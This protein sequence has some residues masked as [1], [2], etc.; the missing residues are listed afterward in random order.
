M[1]V[2]PEY[3]K[4]VRYDASKLIAL[5]GP[6][7]MTP[8]EHGIDATLDWLTRRDARLRPASGP[9]QPSPALTRSFPACIPAAP[10]RLMPPATG[11]SISTWTTSTRWRWYSRHSPNSSA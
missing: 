1:Q 10:P 9:R 4:P 5:L 11:R 3:M 6:Q 2:A 8:Y 7:Q